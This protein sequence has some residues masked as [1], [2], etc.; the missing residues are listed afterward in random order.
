MITHV[1]LYPDHFADNIHVTKERLVQE[2]ITMQRLL[3]IMPVMHRVIIVDFM[4][5]DRGL[6]PLTLM[7]FVLVRVTFRIFKI[8]ILVGISLSSYQP[9]PKLTL[10]RWSPLTQFLA[11]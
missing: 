4:M 9:T 3:S 2:I 6:P 8:I 5:M 7:T 11:P 1:H 10:P